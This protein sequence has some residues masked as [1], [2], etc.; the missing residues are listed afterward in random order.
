MSRKNASHFAKRFLSLFVIYE[1][2]D[3]FDYELGKNKSYRSPKNN[4]AEHVGACEGNV[5]GV[6]EV[7]Q[8]GL[9]RVGLSFNDGGV[10]TPGA[11]ICHKQAECD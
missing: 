8:H 2:L 1:V 6:L 7:V 4:A 9:E 11:D 5:F 3:S 10:V